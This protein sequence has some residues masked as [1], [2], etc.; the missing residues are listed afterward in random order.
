MSQTTFQWQASEQTPELLGAIGLI[1]TTWARIDWRVTQTLEPFWLGAKP[2]DQMPRSF[3]QR[4]TNLEELATPVFKSAPSDLRTFL[5]FLQRLKTANGQR[6]S[7]THGIVGQITK[8][9][10]TYYGIMIPHPSKK[11][12]Y[13]WFSLEQI[14][15]LGARLSDLEMEIGAVSGVLSDARNASTPGFR[16]WR[17]GDGWLKPGAE[18]YTPNLPQD[19][20]PP[21]TFLPELQTKPDDKKTRSKASGR[22]ISM[23]I[24]TATVDLPGWDSMDEEGE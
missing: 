17:I 6:D 9:N 12:K 1:I 23:S 21:A 2:N 10:R 4:I 16:A 24:A 5:W 13:P 11:T 20:R 15:K 3:D 8:N 18:N 14:H 7:V 22:L 19:H